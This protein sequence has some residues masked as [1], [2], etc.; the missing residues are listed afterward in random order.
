MCEQVVKVEVALRR[1]VSKKNDFYFA[2]P[3]RKKWKLAQTL[4]AK[5]LEKESYLC[6]KL[7]FI[8]LGFQGEKRVS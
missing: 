4:S 1:G 2:R 8:E 5:C 7:W 3:R 6:H